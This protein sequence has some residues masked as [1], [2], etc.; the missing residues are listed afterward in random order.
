MERSDGSVDTVI[1]YRFLATGTNDFAEERDFR[2]VLEDYDAGLT[3]DLFTI[4]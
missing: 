4:L 1:T 2:I 3:H